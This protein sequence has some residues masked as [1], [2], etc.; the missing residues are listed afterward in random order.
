MRS[1]ATRDTASP[2]ASVV[3]SMMKPTT[4]ALGMAR[5]SCARTSAAPEE[6]G[7]MFRKVIPTGIQHGTVTVVLSGVHY[8]VTTLRGEGA[9]TDGRRPDKVEFVDDITADL[10]RRDFTINA[11]AIDPVDGHV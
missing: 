5:P 11:I 9:Y 7:A 4:A 10:A 8:E 3:T 6:G 2:S 1:S